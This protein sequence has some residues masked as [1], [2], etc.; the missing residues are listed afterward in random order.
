MI[1]GGYF[2]CVQFK[3][4]GAIQPLL[5]LHSLLLVKGYGPDTSTNRVSEGEALLIL[6]QSKSDQSHNK[7]KTRQANNRCDTQKERL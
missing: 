7:L 5:V 3:L 2:K 1:M 6:L 4:V